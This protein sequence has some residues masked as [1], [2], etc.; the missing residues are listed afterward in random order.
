MNRQEDKIKKIMGQV[1]GG[2]EP[3]PP[4]GMWISINRQLKRRRRIVM[5]RWAAIAASVI[6]LMGV[7]FSLR[8]AF[9]TPDND[10]H[11][12]SA[13]RYF[14]NDD[15]IRPNG[16]VRISHQGIQNKIPEN[17]ER[18]FLSEASKKPEE[19]IPTKRL[20]QKA[21]KTQSAADI[22]PEVNAGTDVIKETPDLVPEE[23]IQTDEFA[24]IE[25]NI[26]PAQPADQHAITNQLPE[27][28]PINPEQSH[29]MPATDIKNWAI[30]MNYGIN[31]AIDLSQADFA[32]NPEKSNYRHDAL[33]SGVAG[34]TSYFYEV[35]RTT[36]QAPISIGLMVSKQ[37]ARKWNLESGVIYTK[38]AYQAKTGEMNF[39]RREY[40]TEIF[41]LGLP[42][43]VRYKIAGQKRVG[44][45]AT[46]LLITEKG[47]NSRITTETFTQ[48][49]LNN[50][51]DASWP[52]HGIQLSTLSA[53]GGDVKL[54]GNL[55]FYGQAGVQFFFLNKSQPY[56]IRS[57]RVAWPSIHAGLRINLK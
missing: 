56:N 29:P 5:I 6:I 53:L 4:D 10:S 28:I 18:I 33:S 41:Y 50:T 51:D 16:K 35:E 54:A 2:F 45:Y 27:T 46:Q 8:D 21:Q 44:L 17:E 48:G 1:F 24:N 43:G 25:I 7:G 52:V 39:I 34:E 36:H 11:R 13:S 3:K 9:W 42:L 32:L 40:N 30:A 37:I 31:P 20:S 55:S 57:A 22:I 12:Q 23:Y 38:L 19:V 15:E 49:R 14:K 26:E 47:I